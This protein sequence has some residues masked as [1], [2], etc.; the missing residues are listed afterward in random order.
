MCVC[1][2]KI[3]A[4]RIYSFKGITSSLLKVSLSLF[5]FSV[6]FYLCN[7]RNWTTYKTYALPQSHR[8]S[9]IQNFT[10]LYFSFLLYIGRF[11]D[12]VFHFPNPVG[13]DF[14]LVQVK[15]IRSEQ[16]TVLSLKELHFAFILSK[17]R[18]LGLFWG[19]LLLLF[20]WNYFE[21]N[22]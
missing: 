13:A 5:V 7:A 12:R 1:L 11:L 10:V 19:V 22:F 20:L 16:S 3:W 6:S 17:K 15:D 2:R 4:Y 8:S 21:S 18:K 9:S 14:C